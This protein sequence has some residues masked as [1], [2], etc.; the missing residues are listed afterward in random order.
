MPFD[1]FFTRAMT[2]EL[3]DLLT[4]G[5]IGKIHQPYKNEI[6]ISYA[7]EEKIIDFL[8]QPIQVMLGFKFRMIH[9]KIQTNRQCFA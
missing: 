8:F 6:V 3:S 9:L 5:R 2:K 7:L 4:G 1:G